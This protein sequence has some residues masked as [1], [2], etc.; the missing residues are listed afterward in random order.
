M[1]RWKVAALVVAVLIVSAVAAGGIGGA[2]ATTLVTTFS[3][4]APEPQ[5]VVDESYE[6][7]SEAL[8]ET[9]T[10]HVNLPADYADSSATRY[11][12][13]V[14]LDGQGQAGH[15][16]AAADL[17][18][19]MGVAPQT[20]VVGIENTPGTRDAVF[21]PPGLMEGARADQ[22][23]AFIE[24][25]LLPDLASRY[26]TDGTTLL[27]GHS[28]GGL[29]VTWALTQRP[30]LFDAVFAFSPSLWVGDG[31]TVPLLADALSTASDAPT[32]YYTALGD[33][34]GFNMENGFDAWTAILE[35]DAPPSLRWRSE[36]TAHAGHGATPRLA[37]PVA[38]HAYWARPTE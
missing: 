16:A 17:L 34:E 36:R 9:R 20:L 28:R 25:E 11:P 10:L 12:L 3:N 27:A 7:W 19:R 5:P 21:T 22:F 37:T 24:T 30:A 4:R 13:A 38:L 2:V 23:L 32:F 15:T 29:F 18:A 35:R 8:G 31:A 1:S 33:A 14:V 26:R 6:L